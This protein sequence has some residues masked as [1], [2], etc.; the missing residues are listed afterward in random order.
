[1]T[2]AGRGAA[3]VRSAYC[4]GLF[5]SSFPIFHDTIRYDTIQSKLCV[6]EFVL[7]SPPLFYLSLAR[8]I[9]IDFVLL[10]RAWYCCCLV[11]FRLGSAVGPLSSW[12]S[13]SI[14]EIIPIQA[15]PVQSN[16]PS[17]IHPTP[18]FAPF[19]RVH[20]LS[21]KRQPNDGRSL[22]PHAA[23]LSLCAIATSLRLPTASIAPCF[24]ACEPTSRL[25]PP[26][27]TLLSYSSTHVYA[28]RGPTRPAQ[29]RTPPT[30]GHATLNMRIRAT[31]PSVPRY[32]ER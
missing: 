26:K 9:S 8:R 15:R 2:A 5:S 10:Y 19:A 25:S 32:N 21:T 24:R 17:E 27:Q 7:S 20:S 11:L 12:V 22:V 16:P 31:R 13:F 4:F 18:L 1:M 29:P 30:R 14:V 3:P 6:F 28:T 23:A